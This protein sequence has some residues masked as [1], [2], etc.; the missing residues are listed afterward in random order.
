MKSLD[1][2]AFINAFA[3]WSAV[4]QLTFREVRGDADIMI[5][6]M[7]YDHRDGSPF[8]GRSMSLH[9]FQYQ[10]FWKIR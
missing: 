2:R 3:K 4:S 7:R 5:D 9:L 10:A 6:F 1:R 8:D